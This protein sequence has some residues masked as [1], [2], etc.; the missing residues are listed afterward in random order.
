MDCNLTLYYTVLVKRRIFSVNF[1]SVP[2]QVQCVLIRTEN[3]VQNGRQLAALQ[4]LA[5]QPS[6]AAEED[7]IAGAAKVSEQ[8][9]E[10]AV[11][12]AGEMVVIRVVRCPTQAHPRGAAP[13]RRRGPGRRAAALWRELPEAAGGSVPIRRRNPHLGRSERHSS[14]RVSTCLTTD[15]I[16]SSIPQFT[17]VRFSSSSC[18][19]A[20]TS[21]STTCLPSSCGRWHRR[22]TL[23]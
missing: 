13:A 10:R 1:R 23:C 22:T 3:N 4:G 7:A 18:A 15:I 9:H 20:A 21:W 6:P 16:K 11:C 2:C 12:M 17:V 5:R 19:S 8:A 14:L